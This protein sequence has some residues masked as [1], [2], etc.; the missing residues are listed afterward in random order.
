MAVQAGVIGQAQIQAP[1]ATLSSGGTGGSGKPGNNPAG[2]A[3]FWFFASLLFLVFSHLAAR[4][5][6]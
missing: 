3:W 5:R 1:S 2:W 4:G 6:G